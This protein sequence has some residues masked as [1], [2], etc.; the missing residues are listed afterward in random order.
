M[1]NVESADTISEAG[2]INESGDDQERLDSRLINLYYAIIKYVERNKDLFPLTTMPE[3]QVSRDNLLSYLALRQFNLEDLQIRLAEEGLSSLGRLEGQ[4][5][6]GIEQ[7]LKH[8]KQPSVTPFQSP[9]SSFGN[10][11]KIENGLKKVTY[12][13][14]RNITAKRSRLLLGRPRKGRSTRIMVTLDSES[15]YQPHLLEELLRHGM[16]IVRINCA[17]DTPKEWKMLIDSIRHA[18]ERLIQR[19]LGIGRRCRIVMDL[20]GPKIRTGSMGVRVR[21]L[22]ITV[23][24]DVHGRPLKLVEGFLDSEAKFTE[25]I[26]LTGVQPSFVI[27]IKKEAAILANVNGEKLWFRDTR[28]RNRTA[29]ILEKISPTRVKIGL[30]KKT[31]LQEGMIIHRQEFTKGSNKLPKSKTQINTESRNAITN[32]SIEPYKRY[33]T[34]VENS[35]SDN[36]DSLIIGALKPQPVAINVTAGDIV[37]LQ[38]N[39]ATIEDNMIAHSYVHNKPIAGLISCNMPDVLNAVHTGHHVYI[40]DGKIGAVVRSSTKEYLKLEI[41]TPSDTSAKIKA[42]KGLNFP[43]SNLQ[44]PVL[45]FEDVKNLGFVVRNATAVGLSCT[46]S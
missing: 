45:T 12:Q 33:D 2:D 4:V 13:E 19:D 17:H 16:D 3:N 18:E 39:K 27:S 1:I 9:S 24:K 44:L 41:E 25:K 21:P 32:Y 35:N 31:S 38:R 34:H 20:A 8:F 42:A 40:D 11:N 23:P 37:L 14:S 43:D 22:K 36:D 5:L 30:D 6:I 29:T 26:Y 10:N 15:T 46:F 7:V 28:G